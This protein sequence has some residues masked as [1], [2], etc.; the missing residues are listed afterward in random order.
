MDEDEK[1]RMQEELQA[2]A[3]E[4]LH[5]SWFEQAMDQRWGA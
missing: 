5:Q 3:L 4:Q 2:E 1:R